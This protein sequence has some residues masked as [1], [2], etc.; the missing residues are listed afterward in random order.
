MPQ[1]MCEGFKIQET[2]A[3]LSVTLAPHAH[4]VELFHDNL[5]TWI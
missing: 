5:M 2:R 1:V 4:L 3:V